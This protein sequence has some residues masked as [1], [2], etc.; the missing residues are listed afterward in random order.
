MTAS[1]RELGPIVEAI[2][3]WGQRRI[4]AELSLQHLD[5]RY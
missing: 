5:V 4:E 3:I 2:G 1:G